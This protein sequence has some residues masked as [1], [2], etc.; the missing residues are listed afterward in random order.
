MVGPRAQRIYEEKKAK[1]EIPIK[2]IPD[3]VNCDIDRAPVPTERPAKASDL[4]IG[5]LALLPATLSAVR[6]ARESFKKPA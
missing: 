4:L 2:P 5:T 6:K 3:G 1:G